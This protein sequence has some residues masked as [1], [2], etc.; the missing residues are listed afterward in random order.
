[1]LNKTREV[2]GERGNGKPKLGSGR[3]GRLQSV[4]P[5]LLFSRAK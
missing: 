2:G 1:M 5:G 4:Q 3:L